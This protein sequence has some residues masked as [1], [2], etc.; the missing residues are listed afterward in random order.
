MILNFFKFCHTF[1]SYSIYM[2]IL[3]L[4][5]NYIYMMRYHCLFCLS[6]DLTIAYIMG[7]K[8]SN[9][10]SLEC[11]TTSNLYFYTFSLIMLHLLVD[12]VRIT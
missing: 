5:A 1:L 12:D 6:E 3:C 7:F 8:L 11:S 4:N 2:V 9:L 10:C